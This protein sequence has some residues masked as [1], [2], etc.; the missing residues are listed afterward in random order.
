[1]ETDRK[2]GTTLQVLHLAT[3]IRQL[4]GIYPHVREKQVIGRVILKGCLL[5]TPGHE[6]W[7]GARHPLVL[8]QK[9][10]GNAVYPVADMLY[11]DS[12]LKG[13]RIDDRRVSLVW[14]TLICPLDTTGLPEGKWV[15]ISSLFVTARNK[16]WT[17]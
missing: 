2:R 14:V 8:P 3:A 17:A 9:P 13:G 7:Q 15:I 4:E 6:P 12:N 1:M 5:G 10:V 16:A 11:V